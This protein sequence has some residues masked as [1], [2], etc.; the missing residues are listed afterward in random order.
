M[1]RSMAVA[2]AVALTLSTAACGGG[3]DGGGNEAAQQ[4]TEQE[5]QLAFSQCMRDNGVDNFPD[6]Q[7]NANGGATLELS[8][9][10]GGIDPEGQT[11]KDAEATCQPAL[12]KVMGEGRKQDPKEAKEMQ[13]RMLAYAQCMRDNGID[14]PDPQ[15]SEGGKITMR[16]GGDVGDPQSRPDKAAFEKAEVACRDKNPMDGGGSLSE[17]GP[18]AVGG[19]KS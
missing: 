5:A 14:M 11:F 15:F 7:F 18:G 17:S 2:M 3:K 10:D 1:K 12:E 8:A 9:G 13:E 16:A 19:G 6:P 4:E